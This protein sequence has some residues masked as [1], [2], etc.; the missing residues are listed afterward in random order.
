MKCDI[1]AGDIEVENS[2]WRD[3]HNAE[4]VSDGRCCHECNH[5][6]VIPFRIFLMENKAA[7]AALSA[8]GNLPV[9]K[10]ASQG[11]NHQN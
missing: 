11:L 2:G 3:G 6:V 5:F 10:V 4:P 1:C 9:K 8:G 7:A